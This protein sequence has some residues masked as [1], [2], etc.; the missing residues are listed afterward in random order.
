MSEIDLAWAAGIFEGEG[1]AGICKAKRKDRPS[2]FQMLPEITV[3]QNAEQK[4]MIEDLHRMFGGWKSG[5]LLKHGTPTMV[6]QVSCRKALRV[7]Q[8]ILPF[9]HTERKRKQLQTIIDYYGKMDNA[10]KQPSRIEGSERGSLEG[11]TL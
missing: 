10:Y 2:G 4:E 9:C 3:S 6:W 1:W 8:L 7:A 11:S 5:I